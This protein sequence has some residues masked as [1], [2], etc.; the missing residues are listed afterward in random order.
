MLFGRR[1]KFALVVLSSHILLVALAITWLI[2][3]LIIAKNGSIKFVEYNTMV[4]FSEIF[5]A[6]L[7]SIFGM[8][9]FIIELRRLGERR[10][11]DYVR[12]SIEK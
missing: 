9:A 2:Q 5:L 7:I 1:V 8:Y 4:L 3:M 11:G 12:R 6:A 10:R